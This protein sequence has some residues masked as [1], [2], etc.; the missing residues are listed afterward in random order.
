MVADDPGDAVRLVLPLGDRRVARPLGATDLL[1]PLRDDELVIRV[2]LTLV[3]LVLRQLVRAQRIAP[4]QLGRGGIV[5]DRLDLQDVQSGEIGDLL[6]SELGV[7]YQPGSG[8]V[9]HE[10]LGD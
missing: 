2:G 9:G 1:G 3:D 5:G 10:R 4:G 6:K 8:R 7:V